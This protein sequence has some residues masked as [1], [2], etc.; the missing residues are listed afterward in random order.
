MISS[1]TLA[2]EV[3]LLRRIYFCIMLKVIGRECLYEYYKESIIVLYIML[4]CYDFRIIITR[5]LLLYC[6]E[7]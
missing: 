3:N 6:M 1:V 7:H 2:F 4:N 5:D